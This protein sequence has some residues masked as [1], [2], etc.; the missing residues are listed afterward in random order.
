[1]WAAPGRPSVPVTR[2]APHSRVGRAGAPRPS[3]MMGTPHRRGPAQPPHQPESPGHAETWGHP[4]AEFLWRHRCPPGGEGLTGGCVGG[5][6]SWQASFRGV[7]G[8]EGRLC[9]HLPNTGFGHVSGSQPQPREPLR[10]SARAG[11]GETPPGSWPGGPRRS[12]GKPRWEPA[13]GG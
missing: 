7:R 12:P 4:G 3:S 5:R 1:M 11:G 9:R 13:Q 10:V 8:G 6:A 2:L